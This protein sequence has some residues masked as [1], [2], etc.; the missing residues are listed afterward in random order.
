MLCHKV[1]AVYIDARVFIRV[2]YAN[3]KISKDPRVSVDYFSFH[4]RELVQCYETTRIK[5]RLSVDCMTF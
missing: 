3:S 4:R 2:A 1:E 5:T